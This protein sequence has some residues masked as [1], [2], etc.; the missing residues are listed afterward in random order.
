MKRIV[1]VGATS[2]I[3]FETAKRFIGKGW[4]VGVPGR[5]TGPPHAR[6]ALPPH[7]SGAWVST[8]V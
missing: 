8:K 7:R 2:G 3:G 5:R 6:P 1:I 4:R